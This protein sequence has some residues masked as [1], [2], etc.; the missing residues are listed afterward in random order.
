MLGSTG[1]TPVQWFPGGWE[2]WELKPLAAA[3]L[4]FPLYVGTKRRRVSGKRNKEEHGGAHLILPAI[5]HSENVSC[6]VHRVRRLLKRS[7][8]PSSIT[9]AYNSTF[10]LFFLDAGQSGSPLLLPLKS[11]DLLRTLL[12][13]VTPEHTPAPWRGHLHPLGCY[14]PPLCKP[15]QVVIWPKSTGALCMIETTSW[16]RLC[17]QL[18]HN[19]TL[20]RN[21]RQR[22]GNR[23]VMKCFLVLGMSP[24]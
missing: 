3:S 5:D 12:E 13:E 21:R 20:H 22:Q 8:C 16:E 1:K 4:H 6:R 24:I 7:S 23:T 19:Q 10:S 11:N 18:N 17:T 2:R 14:C 15:Q 9:S